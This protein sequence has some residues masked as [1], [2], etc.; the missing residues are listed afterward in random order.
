MVPLTVRPNHPA[1]LVYAS[2]DL[3]VIALSEAARAKLGITEA[4]PKPALPSP[5][6]GLS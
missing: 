5:C 3:D 1:K 2:E 6:P 4:L